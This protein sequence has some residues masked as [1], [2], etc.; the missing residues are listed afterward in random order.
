VPN[1]FTVSGPYEPHGLGS[2][3]P[4]LEVILQNLIKVITKVQRENIKSDTPKN[5]VAEAL[6]DLGGPSRDPGRM[7]RFNEIPT[8]RCSSCSSS[9]INEKEQREKDFESTLAEGGVAVLCSDGLEVFPDL[10]SAKKFFEDF[11]RESEWADIWANIPLACAGWPKVKKGF[12]G[13]VEGKTNFPI[14]FI[15]NTAGEC[16][17]LSCYWLML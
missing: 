14:L 8:F 5:Q 3:L 12:Q 2:F 9:S 15:G 4:I 10:T 16:F 13:P 1:Y 17:S 6:A 11:S 7:W